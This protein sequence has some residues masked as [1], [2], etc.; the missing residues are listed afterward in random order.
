MVGEAYRRLGSTVEESL[1]GGADGGVDL[2][3]RNG[4]A[5]TLV[6]CKQWKV[7]SVGAPVVREMFGLLTHHQASRA[8]II[9]SGDFT[10]EA[11][12]FAAGKPIELVD[13]TGLLDLIRAVQPKNGQSPAAASADRP[14]APACPKC[15]SAMVHRTAKRGANAGKSFWGCSTYPKCGG[16]RDATT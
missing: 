2:V 14:A 5:T 9:T 4:G 10:T 7:F 1:G 3:L 12:A 16:I 6:Q 8:I 15:G 13:G 11:R